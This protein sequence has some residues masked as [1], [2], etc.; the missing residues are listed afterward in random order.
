MFAEWIVAYFGLDTFR[1]IEREPARLVEVPS[2]GPKRTAHFQYC[3]IRTLRPCHRIPSLFV[4]SSRPWRRWHACAG[5]LWPTRM[6]SV[7]RLM[8]GDLM[9]QLVR[10]VGATG[11]AVRQIPVFGVSFL[12]ASLFY[13]FGSFALETGAFLATWFVIDTLV[14]GVRILMSRRLASRRA[15]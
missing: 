3:P 2:L 11:L 6:G 10:A 8:R 5:S 13:K 9:F 12:I 7:P 4:V 1:V 15:S 14:E